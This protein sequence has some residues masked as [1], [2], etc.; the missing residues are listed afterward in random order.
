MKPIR[1]AWRAAAGAGIVLSALVPAARAYAQDVTPA[2]SARLGLVDALRLA[3]RHS[4]ALQRV[5]AGSGM[6]LGDLRSAG[7]WPNPTLEYRRENLGAPILPDEFVTAFVPVDVTGRRIQLH[8]ATARGRERLA[9]ERIASRRDVQHEIA[10]AWLDAALAADQGATLRQQHAV[11]EEIA[12]LEARRA[13]EGA[14]A[15]AVALRTRVEANRLAH[16]LAL[17][18]SRIARERI[19]LAVLLGVPAESLP[20]LASV[21]DPSAVPPLSLDASSVDSDMRLDAPSADS[22]T[23]SLDDDRLLAIAR[24]DRPELRAAA[25]A[26]DEA[27]LRRRVEAGGVVGDWQMQGGTKRT[28]GFMTGQVG[29]AVPL[30]LFNRNDGARARSAYAVHDA[31]AALRATELR[32][33]G[34]VLAAADQVRRLEAIGARMDLTPTLGDDIATSARI[35]WAEGHMTLLELLDAQRTAA[36]AHRSAQQYRADL[37]FARLSLARAI[38]APLVPGDMP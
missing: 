29:L 27:E 9:A 31:E 20:P 25:L 15:E 33:A 3:D 5:D 16:E 26:R 37:H 18:E 14:I 7:Q 2:G 8:R 23:R 30:P 11:V 6:A 28:G 1:R 24:R 34:E 17:A 32:I 4:P 22:N 38:G 21:L 12:G 10:R 19:T 13:A 35:A 36:D